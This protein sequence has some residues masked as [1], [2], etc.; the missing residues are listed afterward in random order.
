MNNFERIKSMSIDEI[1]KW[2]RELTNDEYTCD[3]CAF[4]DE[5]CE[6]EFL[7][8]DYNKCNKGIKQWLE[9]EVKE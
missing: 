7:N 8:R 4:Y 3:N 9:S 1:V 2:I 6:G 5:D